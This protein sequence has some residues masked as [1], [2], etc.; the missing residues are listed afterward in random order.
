[1]RTIGIYMIDMPLFVWAV[2][3]TAWLLLL[4]LPVLTAAVTLLLMDRNFNT[5]FYETAAGGDPVLYQHLFW[6]FGH[7]EVNNLG[8]LTSPYAGNSLYI[9]S[10]YSILNDIVKK[11]ELKRISAGNILHLRN[12]TSETLRDGIVVNKENIKKISIH[13]PKHLKLLNNEQLGY[14]LAGLID[15]NSYINIK[16][17]TITFSLHDLFLAYYLKDRIGFGSV[18]KIK[19]NNTCILNINKIDGLLLIIK[20]INNKLRTKNK[21]NQI[22]NNILMIKILENNDINFKIDTSKNLDNHWLSGFLDINANF[23]IQIIDNVTKMNPEYKLSF[24]IDQND[25]NLLI[26]IKDYFGGNISYNKSQDIYYYNS[27]NFSSAKNIINY[28]DKYHLQSRK[29]ISYLKWRKVY[30]L[31]Q[32]KQVLTNKQVLRIKTIILSIN[33]YNKNTTI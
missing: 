27:T 32:D 11:L 4:S 26:L 28:L 9:N 33:K 6:F 19:N 21:L 5:G 17:L 29:Y 31:L 1:M 24:I 2:F 16:G 8:F 13:V 25:N 23:E 3:F 15:G 7:P 18:R 20:L 30:I 12:E 14:Y 10:K 22:I